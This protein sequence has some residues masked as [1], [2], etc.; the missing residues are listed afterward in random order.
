MNSSLFKDEEDFEGENDPTV[1]KQAI[2]ASIQKLDEAINKTEGQRGRLQQALTEL[3]TPEEEE[4]EGAREGHSEEEVEEAFVDEQEYQSLTEKFLVENRRRA[5]RA[6]RHFDNMVHDPLRRELLQMPPVPLKGGLPVYISKA[7]KTLAFS[8]KSLSRGYEPLYES[9]PDADLYRESVLSF[10]SQRDTVFAILMR[11]RMKHINHWRKLAVQFARLGKDWVRRIRDSGRDNERERGSHA[12]NLPFPNASPYRYLNSVRSESELNEVINELQ[13]EEMKRIKYEKAK[14]RLPLMVSTRTPGPVFLSRNGFVAD[15]KAEELRYR[16]VHFL[17]DGTLALANSLP[18]H[19]W[20]HPLTLLLPSLQ[21]NPWTAEEN[22]IFQQR[23]VK[24]PKQFRKIATHLPNKTTN[25]CVAYYYYSKMK[26]NYKALIRASSKGYKMGKSNKM[27]FGPPGDF[28][29]GLTKVVLGGVKRGPGGDLMQANKK[30]RY[31]GNREL[32][33]LLGLDGALDGGFEHAP[34]AGSRRR[35]EGGSTPTLTPLATPMANSKSQED[36]ADA[37]PMLDDEAG[38]M[39]GSK[40]EE[41]SRVDGD[42]ERLERDK[43]SKGDKDKDRDRDTPRDK[44]TVL[45]KE[46][47]REGVERFGKDFTQ[48]AAL[49]GTKAPDKVPLPTV[50]WP[51]FNPAPTLF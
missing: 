33:G 22:E 23:Y 25:D 48:I 45:E 21:V 24:N 6:H 14:A 7:D 32:I 46:K 42:K 31:T 13:A 40:D 28:D 26:V 30:P 27:G 36:D 11:R 38:E 5:S 37:V 51:Y 10:P 43:G 12:A 2:L 49:V 15:S 47:F 19:P 3:E 17:H 29:E 35:T 8:G 4:V 18:S 39:E 34:P 50:S 16:Q 1:A 20:M 44:W 9:P 41:A